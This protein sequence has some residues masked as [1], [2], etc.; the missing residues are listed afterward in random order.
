MLTRLR[1][2][3]AILLAYALWVTVVYQLLV[4]LA[5]RHFWRQ[6]PAP[7]ATSAP[8]ISVIIALRGV[9]PEIDALLET[10][11]RT[12]P[13]GPYEVI[14]VLRDEDDPAT[15]AARHCASAH[16]HSVRL[17]FSGDP[18]Q[19]IDRAHQLH[20][21]LLAAHGE[22]IAFVEQ[23]TEISADLWNATLHALRNP[24][25]GAVYAPP[26][27]RE[28]DRLL[29][30]PIPAGGEMLVTLYINHARSALLPF[31]ALSRRVLALGH[32]FIVV[33]RSALQAVGGLAPLL[34]EADPGVALGHALR[35]AGYRLG[36]LT[37]PAMRIPAA[38]TRIA[39]TEHLLRRL[40]L[41]RTYGRWEFFAWPFT[42]PLTIGFWLDVFSER[43]QKWWTR[44]TWWVMAALRL[45]LAMALD[46]L[47]FGRGFTW[48][49]YAHLF[50]LDTV[51]APV[52]WARA[53]VTTVITLDGRR[54]RIGPRGRATP[55]E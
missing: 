20:L 45:T 15:P 19:R 54:V 23:D 30:G 29:R 52:L 55:L 27:V 46:M 8:S 31:A 28:P 17:I 34:N 36:V 11:A 25:I 47:R 21:G 38:E 49:A 24:E 37:V 22:L 26:L 3:A 43:K 42:N 51:I 14:L 1:P 13:P 40:V 48:I 5:N 9:T 12:T 39:A 7:P 4:Y 6:R 16:P 41:S 18:G 10:V 32:G 50:A 2:V 53:L 33:R 44:R 35:R